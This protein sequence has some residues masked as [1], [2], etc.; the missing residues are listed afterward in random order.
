MFDGQHDPEASVGSRFSL[1]LLD[2]RLLLV[3]AGIRTVAGVFLVL[4]GQ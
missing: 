3:G 2:Q 4:V 1:L